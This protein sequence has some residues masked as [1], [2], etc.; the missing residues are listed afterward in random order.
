MI[1]RVIIIKLNSWV[2][3]NKTSPSESNWTQH[4]MKLRKTHNIVLTRISRWCFRALHICSKSMPNIIIFKGI[5]HCFNGNFIIFW[6][7]FCLKQFF[8]IL[9]DK[10]MTIKYRNPPDT[11]LLV[12]SLASVVKWD[13]GGS[14]GYYMVFFNK[15]TWK[16]RMNWSKIRK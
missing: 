7:S 11:L 16:Q 5:V 6:L 8:D 13:S 1:Y 9:F 4:N 2:Y 3:I 14:I 12:T 10:D 15:V